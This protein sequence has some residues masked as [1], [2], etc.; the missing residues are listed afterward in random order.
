MAASEFQTNY[1]TEEQCRQYLFNKRWADG[2][3]CPKCRGKECFNIKSRS[4]YQCKSCNCQSSVTSGTIFDKTRTPLV[5]WFMAVS[6]FAK[7][8]DIGAVAIQY[9]IGVAY[10]TALS[11]LKKIHRAV[12]DGNEI[13]DELVLEA[14]QSG[15]E[16]T[17]KK[18]DDVVAEA[19]ETPL[20]TEDD[21][22]F[23]HEKEN[24]L[25]I[26]D[27]AKLTGTSVKSFRYYEQIEILKPVYINQE[28]KYRYYSL[29]QVQLVE[30]I[31]FCIELGI[32]L[33][34]LVGLEESYDAIDF[35]NFLSRGK[36]IAKGKL[37]AIH[38]GLALISK[39]EQKIDIENTY[40]SGQIY[41]RDIP[42]KVLYVKPF[43]KR[44]NRI[45][46]TDMVKAFLDMP[47]SQAS[48]FSF[49]E[50]GMFCEFTPEKTAY[51]FFIDVAS[52]AEGENTITLPAGTYFCSRSDNRQIHLA[53]KIFKEYLKGKSSFVA[54]ESD[55]LS[56]GMKTSNNS[57]YE[58]RII[59][60]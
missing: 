22:I 38:S 1:G 18:E 26:G 55:E 59:I 25:S 30:I 51:Y 43:D 31:N 33:R 3:E 17:V 16:E 24:L 37:A 46:D 6:L 60:M 28:T 34:E 35:Q 48:A 9:E 32:P 13:I 19:P 52:D 53:P 42:E 56:I 49:S 10:F 40:Q 12:S 14:A 54:I 29:E 36:E 11:I 23:V 8:R 50:Y 45:T 5:K 20:I 15:N 2:F 58:L 57:T 39:I 4:L 47:I 41:T 44:T 7:D 27:I 21:I